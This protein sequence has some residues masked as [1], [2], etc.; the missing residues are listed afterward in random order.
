MNVTVKVPN[1]YIQINKVYT[2]PIGNRP[3]GFCGI[4]IF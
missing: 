4:Y 3:V 2:E 1:S